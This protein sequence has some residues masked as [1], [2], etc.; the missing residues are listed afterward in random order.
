MSEDVSEYMMVAITV[1]MAASILCTVV[2]VFSFMNISYTAYMSR[3]EQSM[4]TA[5]NMALSQLSTKAESSG[6]EIYKGIMST[7]YDVSKVVIN[8]SDGTVTEINKISNP[9]TFESN[10]RNLYKD[11]PGVMFSVELNMLTSSN[12]E[13]IVTEVD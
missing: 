10:L 9:D 8:L 7:S 11:F 2:N 5:S 6:A 12:I 3:V 1:C 13:V 4:Y